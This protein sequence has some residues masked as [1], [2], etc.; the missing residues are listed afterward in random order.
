[1]L[2]QLQDAGNTVTLAHYL[3]LLHA[4]GLARGLQKYSGQVAR[5][6]GSSPKLLALDAGLVTATLRWETLDKDVEPRRWG[7]L[8]ETT[9]GAHL[10]AAESRGDAELCYWREGAFEV[11]Y[12]LVGGTSV[13]G[14]EVKS[15]GRLRGQ[16]GTE[17]FRSRFPSA[18]TLLVGRGGI[19]LDEFL[20]TP[21]ERWLP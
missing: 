9:V 16:S 20:A 3:A 15:G 2:G 7:Q 11:D 4:A 12:V 8:V 5:R 1:M 10:S 18:R 21:G 13:V 17:R 14:I 6:R 19:P